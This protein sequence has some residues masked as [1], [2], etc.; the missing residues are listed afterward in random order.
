MPDINNLDPSSPA[1]RLRP[2]CR[3]GE[4]QTK[5]ATPSGFLKWRGAV[6]RMRPMM[7]RR[8]HGFV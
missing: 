4:F 3:R 6:S 2:V 7:I 5:T 8:V 1:G